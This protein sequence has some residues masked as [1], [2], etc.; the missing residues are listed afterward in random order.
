MNEVPLMRMM[1]TNYKGQRE[2][3][4]VI[5][6]R[7]VYSEADEW[8]PAGWRLEAYCLDRKAPRAF[9]LADCQFVRAVP[10]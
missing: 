9:F 1:Y 10:E 4:T 6:E 7:I 5:P 2:L 8:H 3:R